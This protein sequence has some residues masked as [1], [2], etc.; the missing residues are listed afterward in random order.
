MN[1][2]ILADKVCK[3]YTLGRGIK[4][5]QIGSM[6]VRKSVLALSLLPNDGQD[7]VIGSDRVFSCLQDQN[8]KRL[9]RLNYQK[10]ASAVS[11]P[12]LPRPGIWFCHFAA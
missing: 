4:T 6:Q 5:L 11:I 10:T 1:L 7:R 12:S 9:V 2:H 3:L 8:T